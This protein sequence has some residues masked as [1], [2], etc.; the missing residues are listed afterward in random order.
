[1]NPIVER[2]VFDAEYLAKLR[3]RDR[4]T[5]AH[6]VRY[7]DELMSLKLRS[8]LHSAQLI[9][10]VKQETFLR[11]L[12]TLGRE[13]GLEKPG[14]LGAYV[15]TVCNNILFET[16]RGESRF[17]AGVHERVTPEPDPEAELE[18]QQRRKTIHEAISE[19]GEKDQNILRWLYL[20]ERDKDEI[21]RHF[22]VDREYLR[23]LLHRAKKRFR[24]AYLEQQKNRKSPETKK[25]ST[26]P[27][28]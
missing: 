28:G 18:W 25:H 11:V 20:E 6:F 12:T 10:D 3:G 26:S 27:G 4:E 24:D 7:F 8:R 9:E 14:A 13:G 16:Y 21:C 19:L 5:E 17:T 23:V 1:M 2:H 22:N 15:N